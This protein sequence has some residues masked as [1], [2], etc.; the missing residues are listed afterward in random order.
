[1][2]RN[3]RHLQAWW[4]RALCGTRRCSTLRASSLNF[5]HRGS[6][7][8]NVDMRRRRRIS[9]LVLLIA[10]VGLLFAPIAGASGTTRAEQTLTLLVL[11]ASAAAVG[12][13]W[14]VLRSRGY[15]RATSLALASLA[16]ALAVFPLLP[17]IHDF[18]GLPASAFTPRLAV[19]AV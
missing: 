1:M 7:S 5:H 9:G 16:G 2:T 14:L 15:V 6:W 18:D 13:A 4:A 3:V 17:A 8:S 10:A 12:I 19:V 11:V